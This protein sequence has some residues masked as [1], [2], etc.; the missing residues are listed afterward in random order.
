[1]EKSL[2]ILTVATASYQY[3]LTSH[4]R[5]LKQNVTA[6]G[7]QSGHFILVTCQ[8][9]IPAILEHYKTILGDGWQIHHLALQVIDGNENYKENAQLT[10]AQLFTA[11]FDKARELEADYVW[12]VE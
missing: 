12:T 6:A 10:I 5:A 7:I 2:V 1:M 11:G 9:P 8:K 3:A 4:A